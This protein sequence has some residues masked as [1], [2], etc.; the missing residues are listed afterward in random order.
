MPTSHA[1]SSVWQ[2]QSSTHSLYL[3]GTIHLLKPADFPLPKQFD[4]AYTA[5][6]T[7]VLEADLNQFE[8]NESQSMLNSMLI[9]QDGSKLQDHINAETLELLTETLQEYGLPLGVISDFKPGFAAMT[10]AMVELGKLG[11]SEEG[12]DSYYNRRALADQ[13]TIEGLE[14]VE[15]AI[16]L[17]ANMGI[18]DPNAFLRYSIEDLAQVE[19]TIEELRDAW[20]TG[21]ADALFGIFLESMMERFPSVYKTLIVDRNLT[22]LPKIEAMLDDDDVELVLVG[23]G[24][25]GGDIGLLTLLKQA[26]YIV[27]QLP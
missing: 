13:L 3:G 21:D 8:S 23:A 18:S 7:L 5:S 16:E 12:V 2:V 24:H 15:Y 14:S 22:W 27:K 26:G 1:Q 17:I 6:D 20:R 25:L 11:L 10:M 9:W 4:Q 19:S